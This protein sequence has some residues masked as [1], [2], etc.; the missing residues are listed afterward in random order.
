MSE[1]IQIPVKSFNQE[2][3]K[4]NPSFL[5]IDIEGGEFDLIQNANF[6]NVKKLVIELHSRIIG[7]EKVEFVQSKLAEAGFK[8]VDAS[9]SEEIYLER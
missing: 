7:Q 3:A 8:V 9:A 1:A 4:I 6:G 2:I 5:I